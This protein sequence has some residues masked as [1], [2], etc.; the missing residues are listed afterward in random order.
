MREKINDHMGRKKAK[1][2]FFIQQE[3]D[4]ESGELVER[5]QSLES[6]L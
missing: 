1:T 2:V 6:L 3:I 5:L 4:P